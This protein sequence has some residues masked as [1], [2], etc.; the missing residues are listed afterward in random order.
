MTKLELSSQYLCN[1]V[2]D[3][4]ARDKKQEE[5]QTVLKSF[6]C[7]VL[8]LVE[9]LREKGVDKT[10]IK[11]VIEEYGLTYNLKSRKFS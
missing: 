5:I 4:E 10:V 2:C 7:D 9:G 6:A 3:D 11:S 8:N 1:R